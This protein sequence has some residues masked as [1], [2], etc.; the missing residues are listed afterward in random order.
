MAKLC[1]AT[2]QI[3]AVPNYQL[4]QPRGGALVSI[5]G[6]ED[7]AVGAAGDSAN[8]NLTFQPSGRALLSNSP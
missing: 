1:A 2:G 6:G 5:G 8:V 3:P 4:H 7:C